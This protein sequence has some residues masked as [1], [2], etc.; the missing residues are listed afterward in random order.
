MYEGICPECG[1][2]MFSPYLYGSDYII[3]DTC[4]LIKKSDGT[5]ERSEMMN[6]E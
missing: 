4:Y 3:C 1:G 5:F 6:E 2:C